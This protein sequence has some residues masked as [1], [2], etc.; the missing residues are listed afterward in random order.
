[1]VLLNLKIK[2]KS[3]QVQELRV[4]L[5]WQIIIK[6]LEIKGNNILNRR[7]KMIVE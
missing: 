6:K 4:N 5:K 2:V 1:M 7:R 3:Q